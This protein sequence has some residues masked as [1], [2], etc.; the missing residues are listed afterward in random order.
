MFPETWKNF[1]KDTPWF[2]KKNP[3]GLPRKRTH[4]FHIEL[5]DRHT[6]Q[7]KGLCRMSLSA[8]AELK[9]QIEG[10]LEQGIIGP[11]T[12]PWEPRLYLSEKKRRFTKIELRS[13]CHQILLDQES[14]EIISFTIRYGCYKFF[15]SNILA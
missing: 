6:P 11:S 4:D 2:T 1:P 14:I 12:S 10:L 8:P 13:G 5:N 7:K 9:T 3:T 15:W